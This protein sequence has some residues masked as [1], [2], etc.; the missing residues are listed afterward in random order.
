MRERKFLICL[1][2]VV[3]VLIS[4]LS[5]PCVA[6]A[7]LSGPNGRIVFTSGRDSANGNDNEA[8]LFLRTTV[9]SFAAGV[10]G[11]AITSTPGVIHKHPSWSPD[12]TKIVYARGTP[13]SPA[14]ENL[15]IFILDLTVPGA[16]P[17]AI[18]DTGDNITS[19]RPAWSPDGTRI[20]FDNEVGNNTG[21]RDIL[22][23][24]VATHAT[25]NFTNT[26]AIVEGK[27][28]WTPDSSEIYYQTGD[29]TV[30]NTMD[31]VKK[32]AAGGAITSIAA[33]PL[34]S[35]FQASVSPDGTHICFTRGS[36]FNDTTDIVTSLANG[37]GQT[38]LSQDNPAQGDINCTWSPDGTQILYVRGI[39]N[40]G[41]LV[42]EKA[43]NSE[44]FPFPVEDDAGNFDGNP[45]W[46]PDARPICDVESAET[47]INQPV[48]IPL[49]CVD[50]GPLYEQTPVQEFISEDPTNGTLND[51]TLGEPSTITYTPNPGF[52]GTDTFIYNGF[53]LTA[54]ATPPRTV[55]ITVKPKAVTPDT[56]PPVTAITKKPKARV[57]TKKAKAKVTV[58]FQSE[59]GATFK[60]KLDRKP[61]KTCRS[62]LKVKAK[63]KPG[64]GM[65]HTI[66]VRATDAAGN[67]ELK[68]PTVKF[69]VV[70]K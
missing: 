59:A 30:L 32:P 16:I 68:P 57:K 54:F 24:N 20:A 55:T 34:T 38:V 18:T 44:L 66:K 19:D 63:S 13:G 27:A 40:A 31:I 14:T 53:D 58:K 7:V 47:E 26:P 8:K 33:N 67:V 65:K 62:P 48:T 22:I 21:Q 42:L 37:G 51:I 39:F 12:R 43:D 9:G 5:L 49:H 28:A 10:T 56:T 4:A 52:T 23:Y 64:K 61:F 2:P 35:E 25:T 15:D 36:G 29:P 46:A 17:Q 3:A 69:K 45:D 60:C 50:Q 41:S 70:R 11:P 6:N 1:V